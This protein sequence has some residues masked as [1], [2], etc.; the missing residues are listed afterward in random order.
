MSIRT[1]GGRGRVAP[2]EHRGMR[3]GAVVMWR[4]LLLRTLLETALV[5]FV[6][7]GPLEQIMPVVA[8]DHGDG[9]EY[10]GL[11][12]AAIALGG[13][14]GNP[15]VRRLHEV[16]E[17]PVLGVSLVV[18]GSLMIGLALSKGLVPDIVVG[19]ADRSDVGGDLG[20][21]EH[22]RPL[23]QPRRPHR[24]GDGHSVHGRQRR[25]RA[26]IGPRRF[27]RPPLRSRVVV[28]HLGRRPDPDRSLPRAVGRSSHAAGGPHGDTR[29]C[30][31]CPTL[32]P[33]ACRP[34]EQVS[35]RGVGVRPVSDGLR[36]T[37]TWVTISGW[38]RTSSP[39]RSTAVSSTSETGTGSS[40]RWPGTGMASLR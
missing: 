21:R 33:P 12:L 25:R 38:S 1:P 7:V 32:P 31:P 22:Q 18:A 6:F 27:G 37:P 26:R 2:H 3:A 40:G 10:I 30:A 24:P 23:P 4:G 20:D 28:G 13:L 34:R 5:F 8:A 39:S 9:A 29:R 17:L 19:R 14:L 11:L 16:S 36:T 15:I 35:G